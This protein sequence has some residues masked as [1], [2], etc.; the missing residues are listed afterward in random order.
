MGKVDFLNNQ[1]VVSRCLGRYSLR[2]TTKTHEVLFIPMNIRVK[3]TL[4][5][6]FKSRINDSFVFSKPSGDHLDYNHINQRYF[7]KTQ[8]KLK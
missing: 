5:K 3:E 2:D 8:K 1:I 6:L 4:Q 7:L